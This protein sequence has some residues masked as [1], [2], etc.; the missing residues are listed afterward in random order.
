MS[1]N[2]DD[3]DGLTTYKW[4]R[5]MFTVVTAV[6]EAARSKVVSLSYDQSRERRAPTSTSWMWIKLLFNNWEKIS[7]AAI[8]F[9]E[10][11]GLCDLTKEEK[12][13]LFARNMPH[14]AK[15]LKK[16][17]KAVL[18][19][20]K[21]CRAG[22]NILCGH[23][24]FLFLLDLILS[25]LHQQ[26][27]YPCSVS[28]LSSSTSIASL[29]DSSFCSPFTLSFTSSSSSS[30]AYSLNSRF[31]F[32]T[33]SNSHSHLQASPQF[34]PV[35]SQ[36]RFSLLYPEKQPPFA[37][38][39]AASV[40]TASSSPMTIHSIMNNVNTLPANTLYIKVN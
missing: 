32:T 16:N 7:K 24:R 6:A 2:A 1:V 18:A 21:I 35:F 38:V 25:L 20:G 8:G 5:R 36:S 14:T 11:I 19:R 33:S 37:T 12:D 28:S 34:T 17:L 40:T 22:L 23:S 3:L 27:R 29:F 13:M 26:L 9:D 39:S 31:S 10:N 15:D 4:R 30:F